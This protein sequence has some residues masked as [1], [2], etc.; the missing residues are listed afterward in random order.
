MRYGF[1]LIFI[2]FLFTSCATILNRKT[3]EIKIT[4][5]EK[6]ASVRI[7][8]SIYSLPNKIRVL[9]SNKDLQL[10]LITEDKADKFTIKSQPSFVFLFGNIYL[11]YFAPLG[12]G[13]DFTNPKRFDYGANVHLNIMDTQRILIPPLRD[14]FTRKYPNKKG[15]IRMQIT[16]PYI[17]HFGFRPHNNKA[18]YKTGFLGIGVGVDYF[19]KAK[20]FLHLETASAIDFLTPFPAA[21]HYYGGVLPFFKTNQISLTNNHQF[22]RINVGYGLVYARNTWELKNYDNGLSS[23][24]FIMERSISHNV[25]LYFPIYYQLGR[26]F[27]LGVSYRPNFIQISPKL[28]FNY[29]HMMSF[30]MAWKFRLRK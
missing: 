1:I 18:H 22:G 14:Y 30:N 25:G 2:I 7:E 23:S 21:V 8:D 16:M 29:E 3:T 11:V 15:A 6:N 10:D 28:S 27:Y 12:Y 20:Q 24:N 19:Y 4:S 5:S 26:Y 9:R 13:I 17:N